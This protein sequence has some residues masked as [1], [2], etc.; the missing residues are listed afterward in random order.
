MIEKEIAIAS[1]CLKVN[2]VT[3]TGDKKSQNYREVESQIFLD[4]LSKRLAKYRKSHTPSSS[5]KKK[6]STSSTSVPFFDIEYRS[7]IEYLEGGKL[8]R[9]LELGEVE[10]RL[11]LFKDMFGL[12]SIK[13][14]IVELRNQSVVPLGTVW[15][16]RKHLLS[17]TKD[18]T[19]RSRD[20][21]YS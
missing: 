18:K 16:T 8:L 4:H 6:G 11:P 12:K 20:Y 7:I 17:G 1:F 13:K 19:A 10:K 14:S 5:P 3:L 2:I 9:E 15:S 21:W